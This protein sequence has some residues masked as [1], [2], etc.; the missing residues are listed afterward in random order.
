MISFLGVIGF[1]GLIGPHVARVIIGGDHRYL[2][3]F[4]AIT[5][6][7]LLLAADT[8]GRLASAPVVLTLGVT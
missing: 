3:P 8:I 4:A 7:A 5:G 1:V 2:L 6:A